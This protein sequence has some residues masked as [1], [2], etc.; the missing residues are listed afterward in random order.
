MY[1]RTYV[2]TYV[3]MYLRTY[4]RTKLTNIYRSEQTKAK[5]NPIHRQSKT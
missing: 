3:F 4:V 1:V 2:C 5:K